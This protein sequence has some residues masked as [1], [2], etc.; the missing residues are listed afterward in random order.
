MNS[1]LANP[2]ATR[3]LLERFDLATKHH[4][5]Q[6]FLVNDEVIGRILKLSELDSSDV[7]LEV[8]PGLGTITV[9]LLQHAGAV[10]AVEADR[11]LAPVL[12]ETCCAYHDKFALIFGDA[13]RVEAA[14]LH[15]ALTH[16]SC[17]KDPVGPTKLIANLPYQVAASVVLRCF[18]QLSGMQRAVVMVQTEVA[19][20]MAA[21]PG[22]KTYGA[23]TAK[24]ALYGNVT[25]RFSVAAGNF[26]PPPRVNSSVIRIDRS[27]M[28][29]PMTGSPLDSF[30][31]DKTRRVIDAAFAQR[32]KTLTNS[33]AAN[34][35]E[36]N[37]IAA[38]CA[39]ADIDAHA[40]AETLSPASFVR[41]ADALFSDA[42]DDVLTC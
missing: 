31:I 41:L 23:Y 13:L 32:R 9:A 40:R 17:L 24:L 5:G 38:A 6:N 3:E 37:R 20:R 15:V 27:T 39:Y 28:L 30:A 22:S 16:L 36:R 19:D 42:A 1:P 26:M 8:G 10:I 34:G 14:D 29:H 35:F 33:L 12:A 4:L 25:G 21:S 7:V 18:E 2:R 11:T